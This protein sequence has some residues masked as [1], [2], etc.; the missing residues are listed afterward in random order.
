MATEG[1]NNLHH[2]E[3]IERC[4]TKNAKLDYVTKLMKDA[5]DFR[6]SSAHVPFLCRMEEGKVTWH[7]V[8]KTDRIRR[9][10]LQKVVTNNTTSH[11]TT[12]QV[13]LVDHF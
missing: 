1:R 6:F 8:D 12:I 4:K 5:H 7:M 9:V 2:Y 13:F 3:R 10:Y 11:K